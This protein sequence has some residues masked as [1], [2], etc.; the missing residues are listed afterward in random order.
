VALREVKEVLCPRYTRN[1]LALALG[2]H[3][4][5]YLTQPPASEWVLHPGTSQSSN[6]TKVMFE[7]CGEHESK[8]WVT[9]GSGS[10]SANLL[11]R[12]AIFI[13]T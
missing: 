12:P 6:I 10:L 9:H 3:S 4:L 8:E 1:K 13:P 7:T 5:S 2:Y 11:H